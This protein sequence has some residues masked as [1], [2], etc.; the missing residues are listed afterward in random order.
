M[1]AIVFVIGSVCPVL[2]W[3]ISALVIPRSHP[4]LRLAANLISLLASIPI[5][6]WLIGGA[7]GLPGDAGDHNPGA[8]V[9]F[10]PFVI[11]WLI[12]LLVWL[13]RLVL[14]RRASARAS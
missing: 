3:G 4:S 2:L 14:Q 12:Y 5:A 13:C 6:S 11:V 8:G 1:Q 9:A 7:L 10:L